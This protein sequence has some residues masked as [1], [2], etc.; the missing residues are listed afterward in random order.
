M[1][2]YVKVKVHVYI[3]ISSLKTCHPTLHF[4]PWSLELLIRVPFQLHREHRVLQ[5]FRRIEITVHIA[6]SV[7]PRDVT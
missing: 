7:L 2:I 4:T 6:I 3:V 1:Y 5:P